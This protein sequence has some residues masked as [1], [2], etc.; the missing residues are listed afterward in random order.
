MNTTYETDFHQWAIDQADHLRAGTLEQLDILHLLEEV[1]GMGSDKRSALTNRY[2]VLIAHLLKWQFQPEMNH[3]PSWGNTIRTQRRE[4]EF[5][6]EDN[7]SLKHYR[8]D[9]FGKAYKRAL[10][11]ARDDTGNKVKFPDVCPW[12]WEQVESPDFYPD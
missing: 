10:K 6:I 8:P 12:S 1:E 2:A 5:L 9:L 4:I 3:G 7:P 11:I